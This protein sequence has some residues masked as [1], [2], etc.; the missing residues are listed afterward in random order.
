MSDVE[1]RLKSRD[2]F[3][4]RYAELLTRLRR[5]SQEAE[6]QETKWSIVSGPPYSGK[7]T[8]I[9]E[10]AARGVVTV[11]DAG[12]AEISALIDSGRDKWEAREDYSILQDRICSRMMLSASKLR[13]DERCFWDYSFPDNLAF[14]ALNG[15]GWA[16][17][18][19]DAATRFKFRNIYLCQ[20]LFTDFDERMDPLRIESEQARAEI[21]RLLYA[22]YTALGYTPIELPPVSVKSRLAQIEVW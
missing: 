3:L 12:R 4:P 6:P 20:P 13:T 14:L 11:E 7:T 15:C 5:Y 21:Y 18:Q 9:S 16:T 17:N 10:L 8:L 2:L 22:I 1:A 19:L